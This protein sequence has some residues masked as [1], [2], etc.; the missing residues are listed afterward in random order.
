MSPTALDLK[1]VFLAQLAKINDQKRC[2]F[3]VVQ[4]QQPDPESRS[5]MFRAP[6]LAPAR[7]RSMNGGSILLE[8]HV[9]SSNFLV[10]G[11]SLS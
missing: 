10:G 2:Q 4:K 5:P 9:L 6:D 7:D 8:G 1:R 11:Q 3:N